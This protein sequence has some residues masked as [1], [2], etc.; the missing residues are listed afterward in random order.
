MLATRINLPDLDFCSSLWLLVDSARQDC[1]L[2]DSLR[3]R[4]GRTAVE[5]DILPR[6]NFV[7]RDSLL[8]CVEVKLFGLSVAGGR[9]L[10][11]QLLALRL[12]N[13]N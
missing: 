13:S 6:D 9:T 5:S 8:V 12:S 3:M 4:H 7:L 2:S 10:R 11:R 1:L